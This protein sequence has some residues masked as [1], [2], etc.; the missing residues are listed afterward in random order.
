MAKCGNNATDCN[1]LGGFK[2]ADWIRID[3]QSVQTGCA[4]TE[5]ECNKKIGINT[6]IC[7][8]VPGDAC[9]INDDCD[10]LGDMHCTMEFDNSTM[11][12]KESPPVCGPGSSCHQLKK[13]DPK[14]LIL[15]WG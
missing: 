9:L 8:G 12:F 5:N 13:D 14:T 7:Q 4:R 11:K 1:S 2:C 3:D 6:V 15:C 10:T